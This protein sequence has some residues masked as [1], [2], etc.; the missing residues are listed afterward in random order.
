[1]AVHQA[2]LWRQWSDDVTLFLHTAPEPTDEEREQLAARGIAWSTGEVRR[3][4]TTTDR[5]TGSSRR[6]PSCPRRPWSWRRASRA[7]GV[8][9]SLGPRAGVEEMNG[10]RRRHSSSPADR[11]TD[12]RP[13]GL[14][15]GQRRRPR[16]RSS[17]AAAGAATAA[18]A[19]N[20]DLIAEDTRL[21]RRAAHRGVAA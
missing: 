11:W 10:P 9:A 4:R 17:A 6:R 20:A 16:P 15:G 18:A 13:R 12:H 19:I 1:M 5:L 14:G 7:V 2:L 8:L 3:W 21:R